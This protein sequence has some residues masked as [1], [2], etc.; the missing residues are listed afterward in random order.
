[1]TKKLKGKNYEFIKEW[2]LLY[3]DDTLIF[4]KKNK[5]VQTI[6]DEIEKESLKYNM[7]LNKKK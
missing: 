1:M 4:G 7:L 6:L 2:E 3:A 5:Q